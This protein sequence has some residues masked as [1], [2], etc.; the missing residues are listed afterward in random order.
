MSSKNT[1]PLFGEWVTSDSLL[2]KY[3]TRG[4]TTWEREPARCVGLCCG[5]TTVYDGETRSGGVDPD[6]GEPL[7]PYFEPTKSHRVLRV[8][9]S[10]RRKPILVPI[11][12]ARLQ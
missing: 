5:Y 6:D 7:P 9:T 4:K 3:R 1:H 12:S 10:P 8:V 11:D 2:K